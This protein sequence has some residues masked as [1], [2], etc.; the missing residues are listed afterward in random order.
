MYDILNALIHEFEVSVRDQYLPDADARNIS[1]VQSIGRPLTAT[2]KILSFPGTRPVISRSIHTMGP[3]LKSRG[4]ASGIL[5]MIFS[6]YALG[7]RAE[8]VSR[9]AFLAAVVAARF[10]RTYWRYGD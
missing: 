1:A 2:S 4:V 7:N 10:D 5:S 3:A 9:S 8:S 6:R